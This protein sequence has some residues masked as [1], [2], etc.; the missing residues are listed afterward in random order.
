MQTL[1]QL[2]EQGMLVRGIKAKANPETLAYTHFA[3]GVANKDY[4][5]KTPL[6]WN[7]AY[8]AFGLAA[9]NIRFF[10]DPLNAKQIFDVLKDD[11]RYLGGDVGVGFK[12]KVWELIDRIDP[13]AKEMRSVNVV[14]KD[15]DGLLTGHNTDGT[16]YA[17]SLEEVLAERG[18]KLKSRTV[19][20]LGGGGTANSIAFALAMR[21]ARVA[22]LN[23]TVSKAENLAARINAFLRTTFAYGGGRDEL[24]R[25]A[26]GALAIISVIDDPASPLDRYSA[27]GPIELPATPEHIEDNL[28]GARKIMASLNKSAIISDVMLRDGETTTVRE[29]AAM[30]FKTL[31]GQPMVFNQAVL[32]FALVNNRSLSHRGIGPAEIARAM[33]DGSLG[34][35]Q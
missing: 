5:A 21:G 2:I 25:L 6:L 8:A 19:I 14:V 13:V 28:S 17:A 33:R 11:P 27:L 16:G 24:A 7:T 26:P 20:I 9:R 3:V 10:G 29:A 35:S 22:I 12:D 32:A 15:W 18:E 34:G 4:A 23:R 1:E 30:G 31:D